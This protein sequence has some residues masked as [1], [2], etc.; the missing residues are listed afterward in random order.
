MRRTVVKNLAYL[1]AATSEG[2]PIKGV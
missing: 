1:G 2:Q